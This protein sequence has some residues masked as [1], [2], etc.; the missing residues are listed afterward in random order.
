MSRRC[1]LRPRE[2]MERGGTRYALL[3]IVRNAP[4]HHTSHESDFV[5]AL[6]R[7]WAYGRFGL[8]FRVG[9]SHHPIIRI[10]CVFISG[11]RDGGWTLRARDVRIGALWRR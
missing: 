9:R 10:A 11:S 3:E 5:P 2:W 4:E 8:L 6:Q 1:A 7:V